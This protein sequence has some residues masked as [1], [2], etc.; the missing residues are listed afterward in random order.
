MLNFNDRYWKNTLETF[1][2]KL[3]EPTGIDIFVHKKNNYIDLP[4]F[5]IARFNFD[6]YMLNYAIANF[7]I[8]VNI[9]NTAKIYHHYG[10]WFQNNTV[11][12]RDVKYSDKE[13]FEENAILFKKYNTIEINNIN[14]CDYFTINI[15]G[16]TYFIKNLNLFND[17][18]IG[19]NIPQNK[20]LNDYLPE[21]KHK[22]LP[23]LK[24][25]YNSLTNVIKPLVENIK[26]TNIIIPKNYEEYMDIKNNNCININN[27]KNNIFLLYYIS[28]KIKELE[29]IV[30][31]SE[32]YTR[33]H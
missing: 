17:V 29:N 16:D 15:K 10:K 11:V 6:S 12:E 7:D 13:S 9:T 23:L 32:K 18:F 22:T 5:A 19:N 24:V 27:V 2:C 30:N 4:D 8:T 14:M 3:D 25:Y 33:D 26:D 31:L 1:D 28:T 20:V 21:L